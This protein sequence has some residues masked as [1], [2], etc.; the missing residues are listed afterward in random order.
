MLAALHLPHIALHLQRDRA[1]SG[2]TAG[3][4]LQ[5]LGQADLLDLAAQGGLHGLQDGLALLSLLLSRLL[6]LLRLGEGV[7]GSGGLELLAVDLTQGLHHEVVHILGA[8]KDLIPLVQDALHLRQLGNLVHALAAG[9]IVVGLLLRHP[10]LI[11]LQRGVLPL[12]G[13]PEQ[14]QILQ[15]VLV[16]AVVRHHAVLDLAAEGGPELL[17]L[18]RI[19]L[20]QLDQLALDLLLQSGGDHLQLPVVLEDLTADVQREVGGVHHTLDKAE[21]VRQQIGTLVHDE[22]TGGVELQP[23]LIFPGIEVIGRLLGDIK[24]GLIG[25]CTLG[26]GVDHRQGVLPV[27]EL[28]LIKGVVLLGGHLGLLSLPQGDHG[29]DGLPLLHRL[30]LGLVVLA[31]VGGLLLLAVVL[32]LHHDRVADV[33]RVLF[34]QLLK[35]IGLQILVVVLLIRVCLEV[36]DHI[37]AGGVLLA[38]GDRIAVRPVRLPHPGLVAAIGPG[39]HR[40]MVGHHKG[41]VEAHAEL[42]DDVDVLPLLL[43][44]QVLLEL[45]GSALSDGAQVIFQ[46]LL[47]HAHTVV[48]HGQGTHL[49][50]GHDGDLQVLPVHRHLIVGEGLI[51]QLVLR[52]TCIGDQLPEKNLLVGVDRVDHQVQQPLGF[53]LKLFLCHSI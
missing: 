13:G 23:L 49:L 48:G 46:F 26:A 15:I 1:V 25:H 47:G 42:T 18:L 44:S 53:C 8:V 11:G 40:H 50:V 34:D 37:A 52:I 3:A 9:V 10:V 2:Q 38:L 21:V 51:G 45:E 30:P 41:G 17:V 43:L 35:L 12:L 4:G 32:H 24:H 16:G 36:H 7:L 33:I 22:H 39:D 27:H 28:L 31:R 5:D 19:L 6:L 14:Q 29:V 20:L